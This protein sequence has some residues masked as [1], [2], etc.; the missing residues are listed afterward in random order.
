LH[1]QDISNTPSFLIFPNPVLK[2]INV[3][4]FS[5]NSSA[6]IIV[7][8]IQG[9]PIY[10]IVKEINNQEIKVELPAYISNGIYMLL[11]STDEFN[12]AARFI[13]YR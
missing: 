3:K 13:L 5:P 8:D 9:K 12:Q 6:N 1:S 7:Y 4:I 2:D 11:I 10:N